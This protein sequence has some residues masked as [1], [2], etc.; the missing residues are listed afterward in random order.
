MQPI[1]LEIDLFP[2]ESF[3]HFH[4]HFHFYE[5]THPSPRGPLPSLY[6]SNTP[7]HHDM[8]PNPQGF[9]FFFF[10]NNSHPPPILSCRRLSLSLPNLIIPQS[11]HV[12][13]YMSYFVFYLFFF[14]HI[15]IYIYIHMSVCMCV[16][17]V[18]TV[19]NIPLGIHDVSRLVW[20][21]C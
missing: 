12:I 8:N 20:L 21:S 7:S 13:I 6:S 11:C 10:F 4:F 14:I 15:Y 2:P 19:Y 3:S 17:S 18:I 1:H 5:A 16:F 9:F